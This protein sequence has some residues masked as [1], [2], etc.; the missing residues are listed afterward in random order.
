MRV[1]EPS[2]VRFGAQLLESGAEG[3][4]VYAQD[5]RQLL[6]GKVGPLL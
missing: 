4:G 6:L 1:Q 5:P 2:G 3:F